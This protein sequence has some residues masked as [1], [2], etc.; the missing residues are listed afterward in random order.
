MTSYYDVLG[1]DPDADFEEVR[2]AYHRKAQLFHPDRFAESP[3]RS[4]VRPRRR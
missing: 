1:V 3:D 2:R 4:G